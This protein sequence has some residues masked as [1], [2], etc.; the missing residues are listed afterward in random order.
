MND[1]KFVLENIKLQRYIVGVTFL[2]PLL[3]AKLHVVL[4]YRN[5]ASY[6][7]TKQPRPIACNKTE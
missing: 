7:Y 5:I 2:L 6:T 3:V 4:R 1:R